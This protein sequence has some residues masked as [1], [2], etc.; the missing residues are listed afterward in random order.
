MPTSGEEPCSTAKP[1]S[2]AASTACNHIAP[3]STRIVLA[4]GS[5]L[6][7][8]IAE[9]RRRRRRTGRSSGPRVVAGALRG[10]PQTGGDRRTDDLG[11]LVGGG[12]VG[13]GGRA[14]VDGDIPRNSRLVVPGIARQVNRTVAEPAQGV[15]AL[16]RAWWLIRWS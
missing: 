13:H 2:A 5:T 12:R 16:G 4:V 1:C 7:P 10:D 14:L 6:T 9:V 3:P 11:D 15:S 8:V